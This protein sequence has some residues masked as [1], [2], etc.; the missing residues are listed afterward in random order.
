MSVH[1]HLQNFNSSVTRQNV[2]SINHIGLPEEKNSGERVLSA[3]GDAVGVPSP[4][5]PRGKFDLEAGQ[6]LN[7]FSFLVIF[8][9]IFFLFWVVRL[10]KL[11]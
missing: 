11:A 8:Y 2:D 3:N 1:M 7:G 4:L 10:T 9:F 6:M 5:H